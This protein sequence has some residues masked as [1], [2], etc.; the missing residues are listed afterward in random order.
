MTDAESFALIGA[1]TMLLIAVAVLGGLA[2]GR[3]R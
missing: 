3:R 2:W 1:V